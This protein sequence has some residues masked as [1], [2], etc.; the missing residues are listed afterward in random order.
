MNLKNSPTL[1]SSR[2]RVGITLGDPSGI[3]PAIIHQAIPQLK[4]LADFVIIGDKW[5]F[6]QSQNSS[7]KS[8]SRNLRG[9]CKIQNT[10]FVDLKNVSHKK[11]KFGQV[12]PEY[13]RA[14]IEYLDKA[15]ELIQKKEIDCLVTCPVSKES[16]HKAGFAFPGHTEYLARRT[17]TRDFVM[18]LCNKALKIILVTRHIPLKKVPAAI[19]KKQISK[20]VLLADRAMRELFFLENPRIVVCGINPHASDNGL[21]GEEENEIIK[22]AVRDLK[23]KIKFLTGPLPADVA[24]A[25]A[26]RKK[27]DCVVAMYH[28]QALIPLKLSSSYTGVNLTFGLPFVRT[29]P[30]HG[31]AFDI[32]GQPALCDPSSLIAAVRLAIRCT[33]NQKKA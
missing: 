8:G 31:T 11:F 21:L 26:K 6:E 5:V 18:L 2:V 17:K 9:K 30:L 20:T 23:A 24:I 27:Y 3:G 22:P 1:K 10:D 29:S 7:A 13:G 4:N 25:G 28:D 16:I 32:A 14:S 19:N 12:N 33:Q 15:L